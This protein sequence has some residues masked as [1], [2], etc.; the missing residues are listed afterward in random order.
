M[1]KVECC[2]VS[3]LDLF[4]HSDDHGP[5]H[6]HVRRPGE[7]EVRVDLILTTRDHLE[8]S[9]KWPPQF[10]GPRGRWREEIIGTVVAHR[11]ALL[12]EWD[13]KVIDD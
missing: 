3:G 5:P 6:V 8:S 2:S 7:W 4:F 11:A 1:G 10:T 13:R 12:E 9:I